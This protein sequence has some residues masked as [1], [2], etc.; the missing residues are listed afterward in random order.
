M[1]F[2]I[3]C[4]CDVWPGSVA[5]QLNVAS[6]GPAGVQAF[7]TFDK[8]FLRPVSVHSKSLALILKNDA[9]E[10]ALNSYRWL[11]AGI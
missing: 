8:Q 7:E 3:Y 9:P 11:F 2:E 5:I 1:F 4:N 6:G 10:A